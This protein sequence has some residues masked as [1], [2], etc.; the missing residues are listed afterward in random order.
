MTEQVAA[1]LDGWVGALDVGGTSIKGGVVDPS[2][3][4]AA[5]LRR[6]TPRGEQEV[7][8]RSVVDALRELEAQAP[9][10]G[11]LRA[12]GLAVTGIVDEDSGTAV[13]SENVGWTRLPVRDLVAEALQVPVVLGHD[14]RAGALAEWRIGAATGY[15]DFVYLPVGT[16]V[17]AALVVDGRLLRGGGYAGEVG[18]VTTGQGEPCA[19]G[20]R[21][22]VEAIGSAAAIARRYA[23]LTGQEVGGAADVVARVHDGDPDAAAVWAEAL[24]ALAEAV[25]W[26]AAVLATDLVVV[27]GGLSL[28]GRRLLDPL[29]EQVAQR[30]LLPRIPELRI[31]ALGDEAA[32]RGM[33]L[34]AWDSVNEDRGNP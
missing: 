12:V 3:R 24:E 6:P 31:G 4:V 2:G 23:V 8:L 29:T 34:R 7:V 27:G 21:G 13:Y 1:R 9:D 32:W 15:R 20:G 16:G 14:V 28:A 33:A 5:S 17:S 10:G 26:I 18:H 25:A 11:R 30:L 19:C 22:C